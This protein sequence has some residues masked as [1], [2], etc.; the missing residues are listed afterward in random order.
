[1]KQTKNAIKTEVVWL[2]AESHSSTAHLECKQVCPSSFAP[3][4][5]LYSFSLFHHHWKTK[6]QTEKPTTAQDKRRKRIQTWHCTTLFLTFSLSVWAVSGKIIDLEKTIERIIP[7]FDIRCILFRKWSSL[8]PSVGFSSSKE[9]R[10]R[11]LI[12]LVFDNITE[13]KRAQKKVMKRINRVTGLIQLWCKLSFQQT[14]FRRV[15]TT[16]FLLV[17]L[18]MN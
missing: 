13:K 1:M 3:F 10:K 15:V 6:R 11:R 9:R 12:N 17:R 7:D 14:C 2:W 18:V 4:C 5:Y 8:S 16:S